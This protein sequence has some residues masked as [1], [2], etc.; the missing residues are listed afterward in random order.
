MIECNGKPAVAELGVDVQTLASGLLLVVKL[1]PYH[2]AEMSGMIHEGDLIKAVRRHSDKRWTGMEELGP[3]D[4]EKALSGAVGELLRLRVVRGEAQF[5]FTVEMSL[6]WNPID[7]A[8]I[9]KS[10][11]SLSM[12]QFPCMLSI[13]AGAMRLE[14]ANAHKHRTLCCLRRDLPPSNLA[15]QTCRST[16]PSTPLGLIQGL[17]GTAPWRR[18]RRVSRG[19]QKRSTKARE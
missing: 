3:L 14:S 5:D 16:P 11:S 2:T 17:R 6:P 1:K 18:L 13:I 9:K 8:R 19:R 12:W 10:V 7:P 15:S 4:A